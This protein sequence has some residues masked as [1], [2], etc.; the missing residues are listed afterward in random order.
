MTVRHKLIYSRY[1]SFR[2]P[3]S[4]S[5]TVLV[6]CPRVHGTEFGPTSALPSGSRPIPK[7][8]RGNLSRWRRPTCASGEIEDVDSV[9]NWNIA[10]GAPV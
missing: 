3:T 7:G 10:F 9:L 5:I 8:G 2:T 6:R 4:I 1:H